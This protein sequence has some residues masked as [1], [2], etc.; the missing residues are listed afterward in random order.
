V[1]EFQVHERWSELSGVAQADQVA[2]VAEHLWNDQTEYRTRCLKSLSLYEGRRL[3]A[4]NPT[5]YLNSGV[6]SGDDYGQLYWNVTRSLVSSVTARIVG[7]QKPKTQFV[8]SDADWQT[9]RRSKKLERFVEAQMAQPQG[10]YRDSW[11]LGVRAFLDACVFG[12]GVMK[13]FADADEKIVKK[14]RVLPWELLVDP[15]EAKLG[16]PLNFFHRYEY[17]KD[18]LA[19]RFPESKAEILAAPNLDL[20]N[21][22]TG[23]RLALSCTVYEAWRLP[24]G[25]KPGVHVVCVKGKVLYKREYTRKEPPFI[26][27]RWSP[28]LLGWGAT[29]LVEEAESCS[30]EVNYTLERMREGERLMTNA[31]LVYEEGSIPDEAALNSNEIGIKIAYSKGTSAPPQIINPQGYSASTLQFLQLNFQKAFELT[32]MS[33][34]SA[35]SRKEAGVT[36]GVALRTLA[37]MQTE[38][39]SIVYGEYE[40]QMSVVM[41]RHQIACTRELAQDDPDLSVSWPGGKFFESLK[42]SDVSLEEDMYVMQPYSVNGL[43][44]T[45]ADRLQLGQDLYNS[46]IISQDSFLRIIQFKDTE[47]ELERQNTQYSV[48]ERYIESWLDAT[49][50]RQES[51][52][53][54]YRAPIPFMD[55][56]A[57]LLQV[58]KA[59][60]ESELEG[61]P[62]WNLEFFTTFMSQC[63]QQI[64]KIAAQQAAV[65]KGGPSPMTAPPGMGLNPGAPAPTMVN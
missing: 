12:L 1:N 11:A 26:V 59:Y 42:W 10:S 48:V 40:G 30:D 7:R 34:A 37:D 35:S 28:E 52:A 13:V 60:M 57:A 19:E 63:D 3:P 43:V 33:E 16:D 24:V 5:A 29:S 14:E 15:F 64:Q 44:N 27:F 46:G 58:A 62:D 55:H 56:A 54:R 38:R 49:P 50:E 2:A 51:G 39:F 32:G 45:P 53:F 36:S 31:A 25:K 20:E 8:C 41:A 17:D 21:Y 22:G 6:Y 18:V 47:G 65:Q 9:K 61:A 4:L 23:K